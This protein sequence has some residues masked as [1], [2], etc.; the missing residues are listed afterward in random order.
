MSPPPLAH[1]EHVS[2]RYP[3]AGKAA[4]LGEDWAIA[5]GSFVLVAGPSGSGKSSLLRCLNGLVPHFSGGAF[6]GTA[7]VDGMDTRLA[8]PRQ[9]SASVAFVFQD[10]ESQL[11][12]DRV[13]DE[14]AFGMEQHGIPRPAMRKRVEE[15]LDYLGIGHLRHRRPA[16]LSGGERQRVAVAAS[17]AMHPRLLVLDEPTSQLDPWAAEDVLTVLSRLN[18]DLGMAI[19]VAEH[20]LERLLPRADVVR[21][22]TEPGASITGTPAEIAL[23]SDPVPLPPVARLGR[24]LGW[25]RPPLTVRDGR[26]TLRGILDT[27]KP[28]APTPESFGD[29]VSSL[30]G[31]TVRIGANTVLKD[32]SLDIREGELIALMGRNGSG[33][34]TLVRTIAGLQAAG[35]GVVITCGVDLRRSGAP[36]LAGQVGYVPQQASTLFF[37]E[38][39]SDELAFTARVR[40]TSAD[41]ESTLVRFGLAGMGE[42][43]PLDLSGGERERAALATVLHGE[44][45]LLLLDEPT[46]GMDAWRKLELAAHLRELRA[47]GVAIAMVTHDV[48][49]VAQCAT[50]IVMLGDREIVADGTPREVLSGSLTYTT[51]VNKVFGGTWLTVDEVLAALGPQGTGATDP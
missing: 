38:R 44:P 12:T 51:Q 18:E 29:V 1:L 23:T 3:G 10:P 16:E 33:K 5:H 26:T 24:A 21:M 14:I 34:T 46:R 39:L 50:R 28:P 20:R 32:L 35:N 9:L 15:A 2:Y 43:H 30:Q 19:V 11:V 25:D 47:S 7:V 36:A 13:D 42:R 37:R 40:G 27:H 49:L 4:L 41:V 8:G 31:V 17:L 48:E 45:R 6:G 22:V